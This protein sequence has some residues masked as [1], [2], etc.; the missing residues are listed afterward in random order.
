MRGCTH[1]IEGY[2]NHSSSKVSLPPWYNPKG[3]GKKREFKMGQGLLTSEIIHTHRQRHST[4][5][6]ETD[7]VHHFQELSLAQRHTASRWQDQTA[8]QL[9]HHT[10]L[11]QPS[12][13]LNH[14]CPRFHSFRRLE[15]AFSKSKQA[16]GTPYSIVKWERRQYPIFF[17]PHKET[18][19][20]LLRR[21]SNFP[22]EDWMKPFPC[23]QYSIIPGPLFPSHLKPWS[24]GLFLKCSL[25]AYLGLFTQLEVLFS[26]YTFLTRIP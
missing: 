26:L 4:P 24:S 1:M 25:V 11:F 22:G 20:L 23:L 12:T 2:W 5:P 9:L 19:L 15:E 6:K 14:P 16:N 8:G 13:C 17:H 21:V 18:S 10:H 7:L 3:G